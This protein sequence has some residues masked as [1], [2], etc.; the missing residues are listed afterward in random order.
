MKIEDEF[1]G[2]CYDFLDVVMQFESYT[3]AALSF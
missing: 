3:M 1:S 2:C